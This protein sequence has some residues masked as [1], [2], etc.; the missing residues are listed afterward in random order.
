[1]QA[2]QIHVAVRP[3]SILE[4]LDL[5][6]M[7]CG[8]RPVAVIAAIALGSLPC[9][10]MNRLLFGG[11]RSGEELAF[12]AYVLLGFEAA[13]ASVPMTLYL[14]QA[15]F[16]ERFSWRAAIRSFLGSLPALILF[17]GILR[18]ICLAVVVLTPVVFIGMYYVNQ[19]ILLE[20]PPLTRVWRRRTA[21]NR[22]QSGHVLTLAI[23]DA[24]ILVVGL[25]LATGLLGAVS[26]V[27]RGRPVTW[28][29]GLGAGGW[30]GTVF[31]WHGQIAFWSICGVLTV[32]RFFT[33]L[34]ARIR[35]EGWDVEL[36]LRSE[37]TYAGLAAA[38]ARPQAPATGRRTARVAGWL[39][40]CLIGAGAGSSLA[41]TTTPSAAGD[42]A[43]RALTRHSFP[44]YD[45][46]ADRFRPLI[47]PATAD[48]EAGDGERG[49]SGGG[50]AGSRS[51]SRS[52]S[53]AGSGRGAGGGTGGEGTRQPSFSLPSLDLGGLGWILTVAVFVVA[54]VVIVSLVVRYG[55]WRR[56][57]ADGDEDED[58][59]GDDP[60]DQ[61]LAA[62]PAGVGLATGDL[63]GRAAAHA[64]RGEF[65]QAM[66]FFHAWQ[67]GELD[68][69]GGLALARG[70]TNGQY[71]AEVT[72]AAPA[73]APLFRRSSRLFEDAFFG[74]LPVTR[75][76][77]LAVW[78]DRDR[79]ASFARTAGD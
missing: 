28:L 59:P 46:A 55:L 71:A 54:A 22:R 72:A 76:D 7:F 6:V 45:A 39:I 34:D 29:P 27:W 23:L 78:E 77:F 24:V 44:W 60:D 1:M 31:T 42:E 35:R 79:I 18:A 50:R 8:R 68:R 64:E 4:C 9:I 65:E 13:W 49:L 57:P 56:D 14:G 20:R 17:Q 36:K 69:R 75:A 11:W 58:D 37:A 43:R 62:L 26:A 63:L 52:G 41:E 66:I 53:G 2:D 38:E 3:R 15:V 33:Y 32:F 10:L 30:L 16:S 74:E 61:R 67:L 40:A 12:P 21:I 5:A 25:P 51:G 70:K 48:G 73:L 19:I 47:R